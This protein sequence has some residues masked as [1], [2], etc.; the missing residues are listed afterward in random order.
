MAAT[1]TN[2]MTIIA[3]C[4]PSGAGKDTLANILVEKW[5]YTKLS[6]ASA[7]KDVVATIFGWSRGLLE[8]DTEES[9]EWRE[10]PDE[11]WA[12]RLNIPN[13]TP[14]YALQYVGTDL[15]RDKF[16]K[17]LW[18][19]CLERKL[20][21]H[22]KVVISD[23]RFLNE[24]EMLKKHGA[25]IV[26]IFRGCDVPQEQQDVKKG[27]LKLESKWNKHPSEYEWMFAEED[28]VITNS[29]TINDL[30]E[31]VGSLMFPYSFQT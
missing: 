7:L 10:Q 15:F 25:K 14:R 27:V 12:Q 2:L 29:G 31:L 8:G 28:V 13:L 17:D 6:F 9:R 26:K 1:K 19:M 30:H 16:H 5:G 21:Q 11:W 4:G 24:V 20:E 3:I 23:C 22:D 18:M